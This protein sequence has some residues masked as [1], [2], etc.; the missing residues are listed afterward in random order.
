MTIGCLTLVPI[1]FSRPSNQVNSTIVV[2]KLLYSASAEFLETTVC[3]FDFQDT[4]E[5]PSLIMNPMTDLLVNGHDAQS[6]SQ[7]VVTVLL[8][9]LDSNNPC[10]SRCLIYLTTLNVALMYEVLGYCKN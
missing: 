7:Y 1:S 10:R 8:H 4:N 3:F 6:T 2:A 9:L 5:L